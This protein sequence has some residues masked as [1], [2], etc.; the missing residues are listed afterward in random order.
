MRRDMVAQ[1]RDGLGRAVE[2]DSQLRVLRSHWLLII[3]CTVVGAGGLGIWAN[4]QPKV[5]SAEVSG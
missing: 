2:L 4:L 5:Y 1:D 3:V